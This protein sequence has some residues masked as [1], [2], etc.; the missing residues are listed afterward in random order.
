MYTNRQ[1]SWFN[2]LVVFLL[3]VTLTGVGFS[4]RGRSEERSR[5]QQRSEQKTAAASQE[6]K[7][8][9]PAR[10]K[11]QPRSSASSS[12]RSQERQRSAGSQASQQRQ[13]QQRQ[14]AAPA[15]ARQAA[16]AR[17][18]KRSAPPA[19]STRQAQPARSVERQ[20]PQQRQQA[21][22]A[23]S[24][25]S[26]RSAKPQPVQQTPSQ[27]TQQRSK[28]VPA[29]RVNRTVEVVSTAK[30]E[31]PRPAKASST[32]QSRS[33]STPAKSEFTNISDSR[34]SA[35]QSRSKTV[36]TI[37]PSARSKNTDRR[38]AQASRPAQSRTTAKPA[39]VQQ[40][41]NIELKPAQPAAIKKE[42][43]VA[44]AKKS[45]TSFSVFGAAHRNKE[46]EDTSNTIETRI[47]SRD[48]RKK[49]T[50]PIRVTVNDIKTRAERVVVSRK[51]APSSRDVIQKKSVRIQSS[52]NRTRTPRQ[53]ASV[54]VNN[55]SGRIDA[56]HNPG[57]GNRAKKHAG[58]SS[59]TIVIN[60]D[61]RVIVQGSPTRQRPRPHFSRRLFRDTRHIRRDPHW[62]RY[63]S[64]F[65][66]G[67]SS[68]S[69][70]VVV[71]LPY[72][73]RSAYYDTPSYGLSYYYPGYHRKYVFVSI[74][75]YW[76]YDYRHRRYYWY[77]CH[78]YYW[79]GTR[80]IYEP[81]RNVTYN[82][83]NYYNTDNTT[84]TYGYGFSSSTQPYYTLGNPKGQAVDE[85][86]FQTAA[87]LSFDHAVTLFA[88][89]NYDSAVEQFRE[90]VTL[91]PDDI[92]LPFT[93]SQALFAAGDYAHAASVLRT[94][95]T[96]IPED[97]LTIYYPR[98]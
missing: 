9:S 18:E 40:V 82:T 45:R 7:A 10:E 92:I 96:N 81:S 6:Q 50:E 11:A 36:V 8:Q 68:S 35:A 77:G 58:R 89:G 54:T 59:S 53:T 64:G 24:R 48:G 57:K 33:A 62:R 17:K 86:E 63:G 91:S 56:R 85:P 5:G 83:Y 2:R 23:S 70:G 14:K 39:A 93:Y 44:P 1:K 90:A 29:R 67:W 49:T 30:A 43:K 42:V 97:E 73:H 16:S 52:P 95:M 3:V 79:Y 31:R 87:D 84:D 46:T 74:G 88:A 98:G 38:S 20:T 47:R 66:F 28:A 94:A 60:N 78:P 19:Q 37:T 15:P 65:Y 55:T 69:Y 72:H 75:G 32:R 12:R 25:Q 51:N 4:A 41:Q 76:P 34:R 22:P 71:S 61:N 13:P 26:T 27:P 80:V 21:A